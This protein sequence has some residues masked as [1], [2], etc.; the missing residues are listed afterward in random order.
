[1]GIIEHVAALLDQV[2][3]EYTREGNELLMKR[4]TDHFETLTISI[5]TYGDE[6]WLYIY[7][8]F[9]NVNQIKE[10]NRTEFFLNMLK[11]SWKANGVKFAV[12]EDDD[13]IVIAETNDTDLTGEEIRVL[14]D[15]VVHACDILWEIYPA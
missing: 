15:N 10:S 3:I 6:S 12:D 8:V 13:I 7:A 9:S 1:M 11:K 4:Q 5:T 14:V 2:D